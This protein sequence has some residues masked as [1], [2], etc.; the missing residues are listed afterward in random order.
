MFW[1]RVRKHHGGLR[2]WGGTE[3]KEAEFIFPLDWQQ[4]L[5]FE[6]GQL[7]LLFL[8]EGEKGEGTVGG[9]YR[10]LGLRCSQSHLTDCL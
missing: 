3:A 2:P 7:L 9:M 5:G 4:L 1:R 10:G 6:R 8:Q